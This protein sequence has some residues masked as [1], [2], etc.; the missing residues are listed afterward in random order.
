MKVV[1]SRKSG[2][3]LIEMIG[4]IAVIAILAAF[5][6]PKVFKVIKDSK[7]TR[8]AGEIPTYT[9]AVTNWYKDIGTLQSLNVSGVVVTNDAT[10]QTALMA[11]QG[12][13]ATTGLWADW[14]GPYIDSVASKSIG[15]ALVFY[16]YAGLAGTAP[17]VATAVNSFDLND[18]NAN[19]MAGKQVTS[20]SL[21]GV[22]ASDV[23]KVDSILDKG[24]TGSTRATSG[25]VKYSGTTLYIYLASS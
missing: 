3:T 6:T 1:F 13:T 23:I 21:T 19:D 25:R 11:N 14:D 4:V 17:P 18:D 24:L 9:T 12:T 20:I 15:T 2:F 5:I 16:S 7:V 22:S 8:F 10:F